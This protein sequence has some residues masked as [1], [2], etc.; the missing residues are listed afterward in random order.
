MQKKQLWKTDLMVSKICLGTMT[1]GHQNTENDAHNQLDYAVEQG[2]NFIDT[3]EIYAI[4]PREKTYGSTE[5]YIWNWL[6]K[7][8]NRK[9][10]IIASKVAWWGKHTSWIRNGESYTPHGIKEAVE[11]SLKRLQTDYLD[12]YQLHRPTRPIP[13]R[14]KLFYD[15]TMR[16]KNNAYEEHIHEILVTLDELQKSWKV[17]HFWLS[18]ETPWWVMKFLHVADRTWLPRMQTVQ[19]AYNLLRREYEVWLAEISLQEKCGL[20]AYSPLAWWMLTGKYQWWS[21]PANSRYAT[22]WKNR[23]PYYTMQRCIDAVEEIVKIAEKESITPSQLALSRVNDRVFVASNIIGATSMK[24]LKEDVSSAEITLS[25][26]AREALDDLS[27]KNS[28]PA[29]W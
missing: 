1:R 18:N 15:D 25:D 5:S 2:I 29:C 22:R 17:R 12:L 7:K 28:N 8:W 27:R 9:D 4:P 23:M 16:A 26:D 24:Q 20:L 11:W 21:E 19:N 3:A 10:L 14:G 13:I 6:A